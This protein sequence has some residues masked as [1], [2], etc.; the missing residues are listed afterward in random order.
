MCQRGGEM[1]DSLDGPARNLYHRPAYRLGTHPGTDRFAIHPTAETLMQEQERC[2]SAQSM[3][4][5]TRPV[6]CETWG[7]WRYLAILI[8]LVLG[9]RG[10]QL[11]HTEVASRDSISYIR[12]AWELEH[13]SWLEV[14]PKSPQ[15][16][17]YPVAVLG[18]SLPVRQYLPDDLPAAWQLSA[19]LVSAL[20][21][22]LLLLPMFYLGRELFDRRIA[23]W[24]CLLFQCLPTSGKVMSDGLSDTL[25][26]L[27]A[28]SG[29][30]LACVALRRP[31]WWLFALTGVVGGLAYLTR[32]EGALILGATGL[33][34]V[35]MQLV[36]RW[37]QT[38]FRVLLQGS[39][40]TLAALPV[41]LP[42]MLVIGGI[43]VKNTPNMMIDQQRPDADWEGRL[44]PQSSQKSELP[45]RQQL[46]GPSL[47]A[48]FW[49]QYDPKGKAAV[50]AAIKNGEWQNARPPSRYYWALNA[51]CIELCKGFFYYAWLPALVGLWVR[52]ERFGVVPGLWVGLLVSLALG[53]LL[54][55]MTEKMGY[56]SD[57]H[58]LL[59]ILC[60][61][62]WTV[63]GAIVLG[64]KLAQG[65]AHLWPA[66]EGRRWMRGP[67][68]SVGLLLLMTFAPLP[69]TL[70]RLHAERAGF[71]SVGHWLAQ[72][73]LA[74]DYIEDPYCWTYYYAGR[75]FVEGCRDMMRA[76]QP[77]CYYVVLEA[78]GNQHARLITLNRAIEH[79]LTQKQAKLF[80][81]E[82]IRRGKENVTVE[83]WKVPGPYQWVPMPALP[84]Q[85]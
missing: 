18:M 69:R 37:R 61:S 81:S 42:Y 50:E 52:R 31:S 25:F 36:R 83:V 45:A 4:R 16:P 2:A 40:L 54:Y 24:A 15:H 58:L 23:F 62:F 32:P 41:M 1:L 68:W 57:R 13:K 26:L 78:S 43:T 30:W 73:T 65:V 27:F 22:V 29:L 82:A 39:A 44:R 3:E 79:V 60:G 72:N 64:E 5:R 66:F 48:I 53:G 84:G 21:S 56:L 20:A 34:L 11:T 35:G 33:V 51:M 6:A 28:C 76:S 47:F 85:R 63:A 80:H 17:A 8:L 67:V 9:V 49:P 38:W 19:Q 75:V 46:S 10:W 12:I 14:L 59:I 55:R 70:D 74:G 77:P 7:D 71:R